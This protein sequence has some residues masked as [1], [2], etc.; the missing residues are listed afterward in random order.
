MYCYRVEVRQSS[1]SVTSRDIYMEIP[2][3]FGETCF[4]LRPVSRF[5][6]ERRRRGFRTAYINTHGPSNQLRETSLASL[7]RKLLPRT[8]AAFFFISL[9]LLLS[10]PPHLLILSLSSSCSP[11]RSQYLFCLD[12]STQSLTHSGSRYT[13]KDRLDTLTDAGGVSEFGSSV[14]TTDTMC[15]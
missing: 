4:S 11:F 14:A 13:A 15:V 12:R 8:F 9:F 1:E 10:H 3:A 6:R 2:H 7:L 5:G